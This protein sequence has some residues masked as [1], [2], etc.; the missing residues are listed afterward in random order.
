VAYVANPLPD[1]PA[2]SLPTVNQ[3]TRADR[4][5]G[6]LDASLQ[7]LP[8]P[9]LLVRP[10]LSR[11]AVSTSA[12][13]GTYASFEDVL[14]AD[15]S[16][17][18]A[19]AAVREV[20]N[21]VRAADRGVHLI[22]T[23]PVCSTVI[24]E[25]QSLIVGGTRGDGF[26]AGR[27]RQRQVFIGDEGRPVDEARF[28]PCPP[29]QQLIEGFSDWEKWINADNDVPLLVKVA[30][31]HYQF[32]TLHPFS[33]G[34]GRVGRLVM[35][36]QLIAA[37]ALS[38]PVLNLASWLEPRRQE[39]LERLFSTSRTGDYD[40]FARFIATAVEACAERTT[41][42]VRQLLGLRTQFVEAL[43]GVNDRSLATRLAEDLAGYP[44]LAVQQIADR[45]DVSFPTANSA[46][47]RLVDL[48]ILRPASER[49]YRRVFL[50]PEVFAVI[51]RL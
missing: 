51:A 25:L 29:D 14:A 19:T 12:L 22:G 23:K 27:I 35:T 49:S 36:L 21:Y 47:R 7:L 32:E 9:A 10:T 30:L 34:N 16:G 4:A 43:R 31:G 46:V 33:A 11:E 20:R 28:V 40:A 15:A 26:D 44:M 8:Q 48:G 50:C 17:T 37:G 38:H 39:Y 3:L 1:E 5:L 13:E 24:A 6:R 45:Y 2:L 42:A 41:G 18:P